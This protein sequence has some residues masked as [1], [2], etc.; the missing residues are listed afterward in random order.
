[1]T[2]LNSCSKKTVPEKETSVVV[3]PAPKPV[4]KKIKTP[5]PAV[6]VVNDLKASKTFD[7]RMYYDLEGH[8]YWRNNRDGKYYKYSKSMQNNPDF[9]A[10]N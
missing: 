8:R 2:I 7:G 3:T 4:A 9:K 5:V 10:P 1:M 6:I